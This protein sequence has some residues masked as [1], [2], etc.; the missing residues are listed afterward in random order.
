MDI[1]RLWQQEKI[2]HL[3]RAW[4]R[5]PEIGLSAISLSARALALGTTM[6][7]LVLPHSRKTSTPPPQVDAHPIQSSGWDRSG[8]P[9]PSVTTSLERPSQT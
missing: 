5:V 3:V 2:S 1:Y 8:V 4:P 6:P 9:F 7:A